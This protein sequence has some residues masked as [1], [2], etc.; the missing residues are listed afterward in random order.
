MMPDPEAE[1]LALVE[2]SQA[3]QEL[4]VTATP[5]DRFGVVIAIWSRQVGVWSWREEALAFRT[6]ASWEPI[7]TAPDAAAALAATIGMVG[8]L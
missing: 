1:L 8:Q 5:G 3:A 6:L 7:V 4:A 2:A